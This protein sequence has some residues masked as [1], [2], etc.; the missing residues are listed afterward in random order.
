[1][2]ALLPYCVVL[3]FF[4]CSNW[5]LISIF[6]IAAFWWGHW[7]QWRSHSC[8]WYSPTI[9]ACYGTQ[10][11]AS[12]SLIHHS[13]QLTH[14]RLLSWSLGQFA[15]QLDHFRAWQMLI[16]LGFTPCWLTFYRKLKSYELAWN[17]T[18]HDAEARRLC[19][20]AEGTCFPS[21]AAANSMDF[22]DYC[23]SSAKYSV[24]E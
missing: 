6:N 22:A 17:A 18:S 3:I 23:Y 19:S 24:D 15:S 7:R 4:F 5:V 1:M 12:S 20:R 2:L 21:I 16:W 10:R 8:A 14:Q 13:L 9:S 11:V